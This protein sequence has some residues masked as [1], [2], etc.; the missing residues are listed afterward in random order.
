MSGRVY[1]I[2]YLEPRPEKTE[3][4]PLPK[5]KLT[6]D[7][8]NRKAKPGA[9]YAESRA[10]GNSVFLLVQPGTG[11]RSWIW[12][13]RALGTGRQ[14]N[15]LLGKHFDGPEKDTPDGYVTRTGAQALAAQKAQDLKLG[16]DPAVVRRRGEQEQRAAEENSLRSISLLYLER[17][18]GVRRDDDGE[19]KLDDRGK[20]KFD[21]SK[22]RT[23]ADRYRTLERSIFP[24]LGHLPITSIKKTDVIDLL[25]DLEKGRLKYRGKQVAGGPVAADR[26][27][28][29]I[30]RILGWYSSQRSN[31]YEPPNLKLEPRKPPKESVRK[32][33]IVLDRSKTGNDD[34]LRV[35]WKVASET[36]GPFPAFV[37]FILLT[38]ARRNEAALMTWDE[39]ENGAWTLPASRNKIAA[40][41]P[42]VEDF[43]RPLSEPAQAILRAMPRLGKYVFTSDADGARPMTGFAKAKKQFDALVLAELRKHDPKAKPLPNHTI[44]DW[45]RTSRT[46][47]ARAGVNPHHAER[48]L[49]HVLTGMTGNYDFHSY[50]PEMKK[51]FDLLAAEIDKIVGPQPP[52][53]AKPAGNVT[54]IDDR[55]KRAVPAR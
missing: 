32:R 27:L 23:G 47:M 31:D 42:T 30:R 44:H 10:D 39:V 24:R 36:K 40:R 22:R 26:A 29:L 8:I 1:F 17:Q 34:E 11:S 16:I 28:A 3:E 18:C 46:L 9:K 49:G 7:D 45:R 20:A 55:R 48:A 52:S 19:V 14:T 2:V 35:V 51:A 5:G 43:V 21:P 37:R 4:E 6:K 25:D 50:D 12:R 53:A 41:N 13:Y 33:V 15:Y 38:A 54:N